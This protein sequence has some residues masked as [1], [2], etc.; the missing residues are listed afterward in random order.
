MVSLAASKDAAS[1]GSHHMMNYSCSC[2]YSQL[3]T[4][5]GRNSQFPGITIT[6]KKARGQEGNDIVRVPPLI[7]MAAEF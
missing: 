1:H 5:Q 2:K 7:R 3:F 6:S 4:Q